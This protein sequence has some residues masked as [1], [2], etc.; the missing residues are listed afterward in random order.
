MLY[1]WGYQKMQKFGRRIKRSVRR[2]KADI[3]KQKALR[4]Y[5]DWEEAYKA[6]DHLK[7]CSCYACGNP[8][9]Y[10]DEETRGELINKLEYK[11][12]LNEFGEDI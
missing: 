4:I 2:H 1:V 11:E 9:K 7:V 5:P 8:R 6:A 3:K 10:F 12:E